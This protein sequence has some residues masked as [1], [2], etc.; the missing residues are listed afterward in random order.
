M[1]RN[2]FAAALRHLVRSRLYT[3]IS[4]LG[5][6]VGLAA[7]LLATLMPRSQLTQDHFIPGYE[8]IYAGVTGVTPPG[9]ATVYQP[10][11][12]SFVG[13]QLAL[14]FSEIDAVTRLISARVTLRHDPI[15]TQE[16][17]YYADPNAFDVLPL[18]VVAGDPRA[19]LQRPDGVLITVSTA[20]RYF[21][22]E[23]PLGETLL[24][25][26][27][28]DGPH[29]LTVGAVLKDLPPNGTHLRSGIFV[30]S[31]GEWTE[32]H[33]QDA[34]PGNVPGSDVGFGT[35][36]YVKLAPHAS[37][38]R[39]LPAMSQMAKELFRR[40]PQGWSVALQLVRLDRINAFPGLNPGFSGRLLTMILVG[41]SV[42]LIALIN[43]VNLQTALTARRTREVA[44][45]KLAGASRPVLL[46][47][48]LIESV[49]YVL[50][51]ALLGVALTEWLLPWTN[52]F[53]DAGATLEYW[54]DPH[55]LG[56]LLAGAVTLGVLVGGWPA[57]VLSGSQPATVLKG[58][59]APRSGRAGRQLLVALQF[60]VLI[61]LMIASG[62]I[63]LQRQ[64]AS[65]EAMRV[66]TDQM[67]LVRGGCRAAFV[68]QVRQLP[69]VRGAACS[70]AGLLGNP[71]FMTAKDRRGVQ[72]LGYFVLVE[73][74]LL[75]LYGIKPVAGRLS[76][77]G[78]ETAYVLNE[79]AARRLGFAHPA[80]AIG[81]ALP[82]LGR[83]AQ[84]RTDATLPVAGVVPD[85][86]LDSVERKIEALCYLVTAADSNFN[87][88]SVRLTGRQ[89]PETLSA[90]DELWRKTSDGK[91][92]NRQFLDEHIQGLYLALLR[93]AQ[94]LTVFVVVAV[95]LAC[96]GLLGLAASIT[97]RR[98]REIGIRKAL[99]A[100]ASHVLSLL[101]R[102]IS[103]P[104]V[105]AN[106]IA[107][108]AAAWAME[109]WLDSFAYHVD[110]PLWLFPAA[111]A[112]AVLIALLTVGTHA[113]RAA[114]SRPVAVLRYE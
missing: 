26:G 51:A 37:P 47:Q 58:G 57:W 22:R 89:I 74:S 9:H 39:L 66:D 101:L 102:E 94:L 5:L 8:R 67:L 27:L 46:T 87:L 112:L 72:Q 96:L 7:A 92:I 36:T 41:A 43:F 81:F 50:I 42:L 100:D 91:P 31:Q 98:S 113:A 3:T 6:A 25:E 21:G 99:G 111:A 18:P 61:G 79:T 82:S 77:G 28:P 68:A 55:L 1:L 75:E 110:L 56:A 97:Q 105:W 24:L 106:L 14:K 11:F 60:A 64:F 30:S 16:W 88:L 10:G 95:A 53:L 69:G 63:Y 12:N 73:R 59:P 44:I 2:C 76:V 109:R 19:A 93:E 15:E 33:R 90:I 62:V 84:A 49:I 38:R 29:A 34:I 17:I 71:P 4:I 80:D 13:R 103:R 114:R 86:S 52:A 70:G 32:L 107:W 20:R 108:P 54:H 85:F 104:V 40:P 23:R 48:F 78:G 45:R 35:L 65:R 83:G